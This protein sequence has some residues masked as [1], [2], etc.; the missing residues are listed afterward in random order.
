MAEENNEDGAIG[1]FYMGRMRPPPE[2]KRL[3]P[4]G[5]LTLLALA[6]LGGI[7]WYAYPRGARNAD[8]PV[9]RA[10]T[11]AIQAAPASP[12]G[13]DIPYQNS[14]AF[15]PLVKGSGSAPDKLMPPPAQPVDKAAAIAALQ[16][17]MAAPA[18]LDMRVKQVG[19]GVEEL[20]PPPPVAR[21][22]V[23]VASVAPQEA[24]SAKPASA[25]AAAVKPA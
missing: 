21:P 4:P 17:K 11:A 7:V 5:V 23:T 3:L 24:A 8:V 6:V 15:N 14:T 25:P 10:N 16:S 18:K 12:G 2:P 13:M 20:V 1:S 9:I 19:N 22:P